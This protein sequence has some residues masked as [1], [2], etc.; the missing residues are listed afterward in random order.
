MV[1]GVIYAMR[2]RY[3]RWGMGESGHG[4]GGGEWCYLCFEEGVARKL[5]ERR[6][7]GWLVKA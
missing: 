7:F 5:N 4:G 2:E 1:D 3:L 6:S